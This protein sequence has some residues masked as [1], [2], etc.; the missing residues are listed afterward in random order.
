MKIM[1]KDWIYKNRKKTLWI[2][3]VLGILLAV[4]FICCVYLPF[5]KN[6]D[7]AK[8]PAK[9]IHSIANNRLG[10][11]LLLLFLGL[12]MAFVLWLFRTR[13]TLENIHRR[14]FFDA[15]KLLASKDTKEKEFGIRQL[16]YLRNNLKV[17]QSEIDALTKGLQLNNTILTE[18]NL[19]DFKLQNANLRGV[20]LERADL[21]RVDLERVDLE[22][23]DL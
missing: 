12:P 6:V 7:L 8:E 21:E 14:A 20:D 13:D 10:S 2:A 19:K 18:I 23:A 3:G 11:S 15:L 17:Y 5:I 1:G 16:A 4:L 9:S 22:R